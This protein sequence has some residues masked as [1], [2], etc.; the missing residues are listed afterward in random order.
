MRVLPPTR[1][2]LTVVWFDGE[3]LC[4]RFFSSTADAA[5]FAKSVP[6][7]VLIMSADALPI[8]DAFIT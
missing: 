5:G 4:Y 8:G 1:E 7:A 6:G 3:R 2:N